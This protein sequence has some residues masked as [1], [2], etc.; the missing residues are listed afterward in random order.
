MKTASF[1]DVIEYPYQLGIQSYFT[2]DTGYYPVFRLFE[3]LYNAITI[4]NRSS[5][6][7][8]SELAGHFTLKS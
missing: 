5:G 3:S 4:E 1:Y 7:T 2:E 8:P 6:C